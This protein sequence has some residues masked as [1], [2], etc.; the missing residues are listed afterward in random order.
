MNQIKLDGLQWD[1]K[2]ELVEKL[3]KKVLVLQAVVKDEGD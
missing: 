2:F 3:D 1:P